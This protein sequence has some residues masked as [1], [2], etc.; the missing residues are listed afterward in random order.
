MMGVSHAITDCMQSAT[1]RVVKCTGNN[2]S[3]LYNFGYSTFQETR[4]KSNFM[5]TFERQKSSLLYKHTL[6]IAC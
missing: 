5:L 2:L 6:L 4:L 1:H 3:T